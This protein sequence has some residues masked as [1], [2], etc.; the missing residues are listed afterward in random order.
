VRMHRC[1]AHAALTRLQAERK[2]HPDQRHTRCRLY[3]MLS[4]CISA[5]EGVAVGIV[6]ASAPLCLP[7]PCVTT[8]TLLPVALMRQACLYNRLIGARTR[9]RPFIRPRK[10][11]RHPCVSTACPR[12]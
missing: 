1:S 9:L 10:G 5:R 6:G 11:P 2:R 8:F 12:P 7:S 3:T 4:Y